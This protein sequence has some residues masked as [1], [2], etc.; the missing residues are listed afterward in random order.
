MSKKESNSKLS[1]LNVQFEELNVEH[2]ELLKNTFLTVD[3]N[4]KEE[5]KN[6]IIEVKNNL[7]TAPSTIFYL[8]QQDTKTQ[9][10][11]RIMRYVMFKLNDVDYGIRDGDL[12]IFLK[13]LE[14]IILNLF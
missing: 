9:R 13:L 1:D 4:T 3:D 12:D 10:L 7:T 11:E 8:L 14:K 5:F 6:E 2:D